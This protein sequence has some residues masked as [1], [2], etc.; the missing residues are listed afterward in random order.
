MKDLREA[1]GVVGIFG[2]PEA[3]RFAYLGL[4]ALQH[5]GQESAGIV[6]VK[7]KTVRLEVGMGLV[8]DVFTEEKLLRLTGDAAVGHVRYSTAGESDIASA[9]PILVSGYRGPIALGHNGNLVN[10]RNLRRSLEA[11]GAIFRTSSDS[12]VILHLI[13]RSRQKTLPDAILDALL[14]VRGAYSLTFLTPTSLI[15]VRDPRGFRPLALGRIGEGYVVA[16]ETCAFD[17]LGAEYM[18]EIAPGELLKID[19]TGLKTFDALPNRRK[20]HCVFEQIYFARPDS[21]VFGRSVNRSRQ[22]M[23]WRLFQESPAEADIV[24]PVPDS[25]VVASL[26]YSQAS[27]LPFRMGLIRNHY[28]GRTFIEPSQSIRNFGVKIKLNPVRSVIEGRR[29]VLIDDSIVR[30]TTSRKIVAMLKAVGAA[31][32]HV[33]ISSP[34]TIGSCYYGIDTPSESELI[35]AGESVE[36]IRKFVGADSLAYLSLDGLREATEI[37]EDDFCLGC[38]DHRYPLSVSDDERRQMKLFDREQ[39][40]PSDGGPGKARL[41]PTVRE[42]S[43]QI[44]AE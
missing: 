36:G 1:C 2:V 6:A 29:V 8:A 4:Y 18:R 41:V 34:P 25:G 38:F 20:A 40:S 37:T 31:E 9:Q 27:G 32:V 10:A 22:R 24:V 21:L 42:L 35:A 28:V 5:R 19:R 30:G 17:L 44:V 43:Q 7:E 33:R 13:A 11:D 39:V 3:A 26:G 23:G 12:E 15:A 16:S 14:K